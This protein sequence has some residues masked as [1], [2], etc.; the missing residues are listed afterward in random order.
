MQAAMAAKQQL[1]QPVKAGENTLSRLLDEMCKPGALDRR[2]EGDRHLLEYV[3]AE[4]R[5][6]SSEVFSKFMSDIYV[7][8]GGMAIKRYAQPAQLAQ[9]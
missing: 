1:M 7:R 2:R 5:D 9:A 6:L 8:I 3:E 4:G